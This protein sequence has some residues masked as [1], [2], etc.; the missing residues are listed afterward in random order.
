M[1]S[2]FFCVPFWRRKW[3]SIVS[4]PDHCLFI[5]FLKVSRDMT[6]PT[7]MT[8]RPVNTQISLGIR[9]V[10]SESSLSAKKLGSLATHCAHSE[11]TDQTGRMPRVIW[12]FDGRTLILL[13]LS[14]RISDC[15]GK[16]IDMLIRSMQIFN[17]C[18]TIIL[19]YQVGFL[20][21]TNAKLLLAG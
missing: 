8:V 17:N 18:W 7:K 2:W 21:Q 4:V 19:R 14:C 16:R 11:D 1:P 20:L 10:W 12:V 5:Y 13:V 6:K 3:S 9:P 15:S